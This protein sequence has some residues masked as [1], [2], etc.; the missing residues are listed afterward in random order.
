MTPVAWVARQFP[1]IGAETQVGLSLQQP[2][3]LDEIA[4]LVRALLLGPRAAK[5]LRG[6]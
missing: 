4:E 5:R 6:K 2:V 3:P 1:Q